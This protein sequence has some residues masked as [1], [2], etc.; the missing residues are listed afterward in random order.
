MS[1][2]YVNSLENC[3][4][5][6]IPPTDFSG[7]PLHRHQLCVSKAALLRGIVIIVLFNLCLVAFVY[8]LHFYINTLPEDQRNNVN[9]VFCSVGAL[10]LCITLIK[11]GDFS[12][13]NPN[14]Y[15]I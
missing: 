10:L 8:L 9:T 2:L 13:N 11:L 6:N 12:K 15:Y 7:Q 14:F 3:E 1:K 4:L 5:G